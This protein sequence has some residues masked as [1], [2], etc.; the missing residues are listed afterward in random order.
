MHRPGIASVSGSKIILHG[1]TIDEVKRY[2]RK[3]LILCVE[4]ANDEE[5][6]FLERTQ[7]EEERRRKQ[8]EDYRKTVEDGASDLTFD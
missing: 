7:K 8:K 6:K 5:E 2:H 3:T 1:T 4:K